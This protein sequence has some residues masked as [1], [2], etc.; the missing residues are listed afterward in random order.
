MLMKV[1]SKLEDDF[2]IYVFVDYV[3]IFDERAFIV[4][5]KKRILNCIF[6]KIKLE[7]SWGLGQ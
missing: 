6:F 3:L 5:E 1:S 4:K 7:K 2:Y